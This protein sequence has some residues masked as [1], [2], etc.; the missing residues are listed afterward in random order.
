MSNIGTMFYL[1]VQGIASKGCLLAVHVD[2]IRD[3]NILK[4]DDL[5]PFFLA[6]VHCI[7][8]PTCLTWCILLK[9]V[10]ESNHTTTLI[11]L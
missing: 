3:F 8:G 4:K 10:G 1:L 6:H 7:I 9:N 11:E 5:L 2:G